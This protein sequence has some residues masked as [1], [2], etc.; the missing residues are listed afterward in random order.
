L[1]AD[2]IRSGDD[3]SLLII[4]APLA[5]FACT[6]MKMHHGDGPLW[7]AGGVKTRFAGIELTDSGNTEPCHQRRA[8]YVCSDAAAERSRR[9]DE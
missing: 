2:V 1:V 8:G 6:V 3:G 4:A 5:R 7:C 9:S